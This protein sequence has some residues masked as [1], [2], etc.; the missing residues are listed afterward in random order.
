[1]LELWTIE[2][3]DSVLET[4]GNNED[5]AKQMV[6]TMA[7][8]LRAQGKWKG[9]FGHRNLTTGDQDILNVEIDRLLIVIRVN[10]GLWA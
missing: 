7:T 5:F 9:S 6:Q 8:R 10:V 2:W 4:F 1:M 3:D